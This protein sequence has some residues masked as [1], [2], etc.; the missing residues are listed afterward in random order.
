MSKYPNKNKTRK[1]IDSHVNEFLGRMKEDNDHDR[2]ELMDWFNYCR[3]KYPGTFRGWSLGQ[4]ERWN[5]LRIA[6][7]DKQPPPQTT[8]EARTE[9][10]ARCAKRIMLDGIDA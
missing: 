9:I 8:E 2:A 1:A 10:E 5:D 3:R 4:F 7:L 6:E